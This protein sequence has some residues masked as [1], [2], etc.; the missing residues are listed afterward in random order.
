L[1]YDESVGMNTAIPPNKDNEERPQSSSGQT[2]IKGVIETP[3]KTPNEFAQPPRSSP[4][5]LAPLSGIIKDELFLIGFLILCVGVIFSDAYYARF[6]VKYQF[7]NFP[8]FHIIYRGLTALI[9]APYLFLPYLLAVAWLGLD[10]YAMRKEWDAFLR[11]R[12]PASYLLLFLVLAL[13]YPL[14]IRAGL[15]QAE[16]DLNNQTSTLPQ[17]A[18]MVTKKDEFRQPED[19]Y[20]LLMI[21]G[22]FVIIFRPLE[23]SDQGVVP[24]IK[25]YSKGD[26]YVIETI[27]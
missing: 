15:K 12:T 1:T 27:P 2:E 22:D 14:A 8:S 4:D 11:F 17:V 10:I 24:K 18:K 19:N 9:G 23:P 5:R 25:R 3:P 7:L 16:R 6:G 20:R 26:V 21:D 13:C